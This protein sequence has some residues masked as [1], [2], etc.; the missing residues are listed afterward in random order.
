MLITAAIVLSAGLSYRVNVLYLGAVVGLAGLIIIIRKPQ[1]GI[2]GL[3]PASMVIPVAISTGTGTE[4]NATIGLL[5]VLIVLWLLSMLLRRQVRF[6]SSPVMLPAISFIIAAI[7]AFLAGQLPWFVTKPAPIAAQIGGL[8]LMLLTVASVILMA[9]QMQDVRWLRWLTYAFLGLSAVYLASRIIPGG[10]PITRLFLYGSDSSMFWTWVVSMALSQALVNRGLKKG[11]RLAFL[12]IVGAALY[13]GMI[14]VRDWTS[15]WMPAALS[16]IVILW[17]AQPRLGLLATIA[18]GIFVV[19]RL[20]SLV[21]LIYIGD[22]EYS[23]FTRVEAWR[24]L[25]EIVQVNPILGLGP[26]NYYWYTPLFPIL[27]YAVSFNSHN[28]YIDL[29]AQTGVLGLACF[30][31]FA[32]SLLRVGWRMLRL[33]MQLP[34]AEVEHTGPPNRLARPA[35]KQAEPRLYG[36]FNL[37]DAGFIHAFVVGAMG[38][39]VATL[40]S[41][42]LGDWFM[43]F[44]YNVGFVGFRS[45][46]FGWLFVGGMIAIEQIIKARMPAPEPVKVPVAPP[47]GAPQTQRI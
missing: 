38:G 6:V 3:V 44:V 11:W 23:A 34:P 37:A 46:V 12:G 32:V 21:D 9:H 40:F 22:N 10:R 19:F 16:I 45:A 4:I 28:N 17:L 31:W 29:V 14:L 25:L 20:Q 36:L 15:G 35:P 24:I 8:L 7:L 1:L 18:G 2:V 39:L 47:I 27:G 30:L 41:G 26:A 43:P 13:I 33:H 42:M 5:A